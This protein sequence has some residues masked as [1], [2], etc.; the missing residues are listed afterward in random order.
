MSAHS[1]TL[2]GIVAYASDAFVLEATVPEITTS[3]ERFDYK[4]V[5]ETMNQINGHA[6]GENVQH[7]EGKAIDE[8]QFETN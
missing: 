6:T 1:N 2:D 5:S 7:E 3:H 8:R 4:N